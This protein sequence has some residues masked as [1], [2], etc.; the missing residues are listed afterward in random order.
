MSM[1]LSTRPIDLLPLVVD[2]P[3]GS[4]ASVKTMHA[5]GR[6]SRRWNSTRSS[7][8]AVPD[9]MSFH[10]VCVDV[11][12]I[13]ALSCFGGAS[14][15]GTEIVVVSKVSKE[16]LSGESGD[17]TCVLPFVNVRTRLR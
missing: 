10:I 1:R 3:S 11:S 14:G 9:F 5:N 17:T 13:V 12:W 2:T 7:Y 6:A 15:M 16:Y 8:V 4:P